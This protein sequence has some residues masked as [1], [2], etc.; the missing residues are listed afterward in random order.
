MQSGLWGEDFID[1]DKVVKLTPR[2]TGLH[3]A[4]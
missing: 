2:R 1:G 3:D 4:E